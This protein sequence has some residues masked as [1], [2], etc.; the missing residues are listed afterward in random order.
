[1]SRVSSR[2][3]FVAFNT[4]YALLRQEEQVRCFRN[5]AAHL[6]AGGKFVVE[7]FV[8]DMTRFV[9][10][11][12]VRVYSVTT[13]QVSLQV[14]HHDSVS[15]RLKSQFVVFGNNGLKLYPVEIRYCWPSELDL[16]GE[17]A[18]LRPVNRWGSWSRAE[19]NAASEKHITVYERCQSD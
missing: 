18:G 1:M 2:L 5:V 12:S 17:L 10:G 13:E 9:G 4:I 3:S 11:Q 6:G 14:S 16:M 19:F 15:Q 7:A 8:P